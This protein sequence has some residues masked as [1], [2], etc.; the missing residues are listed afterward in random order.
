MSN[1]RVT[2]AAQVLGYMKKE[3]RI[4]STVIHGLYG[5]SNAPA[6][7][8]QLRRRGVEVITT[9]KRGFRGSYAEYRLA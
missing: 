1:R 6:V 4:T 3:G 5:I 8:Y 7:I 2:Q 9:K